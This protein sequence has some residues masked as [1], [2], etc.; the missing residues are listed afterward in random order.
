MI[1]KSESIGTKVD[2]DAIEKA[3]EIPRTYLVTDKFGRKFFKM[4]KPSEAQKIFKA[5]DCSGVIVGVLD[6]RH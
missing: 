4:Y 2:W 6:R 3:T 1:T 5:T